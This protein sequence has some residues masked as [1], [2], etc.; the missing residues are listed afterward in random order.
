MN[1]EIA[2]K[3]WLNTEGLEGE[4]RQQLQELAQ[5]ET[6]LEDAFY[7][8]LEFGTGGMRGE[9][10][11]GTNRMNIYTIRKASAGLAAY[12]EQQ[13]TKA[14]AR[15]V[16]I[17]YDCRHKSPEFA[18]EAAKTLASRGI[19]TYVFES[20]RPT[21]ELSFA[22]RYLKAAGGIV[23]TAS[24]NPPEYNGYKVYGGDGGQLPLK[25]ADLLT[26]KVN[27]VQ[28]ELQIETGSKEELM[29]KGLIEIIGAE[30]DEAYNEQL[31]KITVNPDVIRE[32]HDLKIVFTPLHGTANH[33]VQKGLAA[34]G[35]TNVTVVAEQ[36][37]PDPNFSTV[38]SPNPEEHAAF[39]LAIEY[40]EKQGADLLLATDPDADRVGVAVKNTEG[41]YVVLTGN[42]TG[43]LLLH[44]L[45][46]ER[47]KQ[48][49]LSPN[50]VVLKTIVTSELG[51]AIADA[52]HL[53][54][55]DTLTGFKFIGEK[56][57]EF[58]QSKEHTFVFGYEES[59][60]YLIGDFVRD[61]DAVQACLFAAEVAAYY[62]KQGKTLYEALLDLYETY[63]Y[64][65]EGLQSITMKGKAG[66]EQ[67]Q[68]ILET[69]RSTPLTKVAGKDVLFTEDYSIQKGMNM[70]T[71]EPY[72]IELPAS[73]VLKYKLADGSWFCLRPSGTEPKIK[74]YFAV[75]GASEKEG[76]AMLQTLM[77]EVMQRV[78]AAADTK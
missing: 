58:E 62:K 43:A 76:K 63:G 28:D 10:G 41:E 70:T 22:V 61:K 24:H 64:H 50:G 52:Y 7:K 25:E 69:F 59:Y 2:Y 56:I 18:M 60:G 47:Q 51:A 13:G 65:Y 34:L 39:K 73:N 5:T 15:G 21:P 54:T 14:A 66:A 77:N 71:N 1:W 27:E 44:Y 48:N 6:G 20:L 37:E 8:N 67:I 32:M 55:I 75:K 17:A 38:T 68:A 11:P 3:K 78:Q 53:T 29:A 36:A 46:S 31:K 72:D 16:V 42:Q 35:F 57:K 23:I 12:I 9:I 33:P 40:G 4:L 49:R 30:I 26:E 19:K 74:F 45:V